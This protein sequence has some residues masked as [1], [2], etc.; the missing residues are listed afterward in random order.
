MKVAFNTM[1]KN[2]SKLL[3]VVLPIWS[4]YKIDLFVF[5]DDNSTDNSHEIIAK[6]LSSDRYQII[7]DHLPEFNESHQRQRM[8]DES[9]MRDV[10]IILTIDAD[11]LLT[12]TIVNDFDNFLNEYKTNDMLLFWY[13]SVNDSISY[14]RND[15]SYTNNYRSFVLPVDKIGRLN[16]ANFKYHTPRTPAVHLPKTYTKKYGVI[17]LQAANTRFY[18]IKQLWYKHH[19]FV[20]YGHSI[21]FIN[22]RYDS[23][24]NNFNFNPVKID[25]ELIEGIDIDL[26]VFDRLE[27]EKGYLDFIRKNYNEKLVTFGKQYL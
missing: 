15:P 16:S 25:D 4:K 5:Y 20:K 9:I 22:D 10:D 23:V 21:E 17:H 1:F 24:V 13:N 2:E 14:Y 11:E 26:T 7:N 3:D 18:A 12:S 6:H 8:I 27:E 19:E